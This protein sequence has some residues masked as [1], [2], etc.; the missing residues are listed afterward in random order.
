MKS[1]FVSKLLRVFCFLF[2][3]TSRAGFLLLPLL[4]L[5]TTTATNWLLCVLFTGI[6]VC[7]MV[8]L[9]L[10][11]CLRMRRTCVC[12]LFVTGPGSRSRKDQEHEFLIAT[13]GAAE[14][15]GAGV[16]ACAGIG[17]GRFLIAGRP[18]WVTALVT[19]LRKTGG[20]VTVYTEHQ[21][22]TRGGWLAS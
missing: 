14:R 1:S 19:A 4:L 5:T 22:L 3:V 8:S 16:I 21:E 7:T 18:Y 15:M 10:R 17:A 11:R 12:G 20:D 13:G 9:H 2:W 6:I